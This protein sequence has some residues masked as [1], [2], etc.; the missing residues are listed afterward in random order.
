MHIQKYIPSWTYDPYSSYHTC[1]IIK[2]Y[3]SES[4]NLVG[5]FR[6][7]ATGHSFNY[8]CIPLYQFHSQF[9][10]YF[11]YCIVHFH[12]CNLH[13]DMILQISFKGS[14]GK[15][16]LSNNGRETMAKIN[17][18]QWKCLIYK[19]KHRKEGAFDQNINLVFKETFIIKDVL[20]SVFK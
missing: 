13:H 12:P 16:D 3:D 7:T 4:T 2:G 11:L 8:L 5:P 15:T 10:A 6:N 20:I 18:L 19:T 1:G 14:Q 17:T 9:P